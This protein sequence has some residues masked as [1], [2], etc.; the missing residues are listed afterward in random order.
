MSARVRVSVLL[1]RR[2]VDCPLT[3]VAY[4]KTFYMQFLIKRGDS[5]SIFNDLSDNGLPCGGKLWSQVSYM[6]ATIM[7]PQPCDEI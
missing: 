4:T 2:L 7:P 3:T 5:Y 1:L 6:E